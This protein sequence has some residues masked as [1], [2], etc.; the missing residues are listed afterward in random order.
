MICFGEPLKSTHHLVFQEIKGK[1]SFSTINFNQREGIKRKETRIYIGL[2]FKGEVNGFR[3]VVASRSNEVNTSV[4][5]DKL[6][7]VVWYRLGHR[8]MTRVGV[9]NI[10]WIRTLREGGWVCDWHRS[11]IRRKLPR[12]SGM[13]GSRGTSLCDTAHL[14]SLCDGRRA[15]VAL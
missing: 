14:Q 1:L 12:V 7:D 10:F 6:F 8:G 3:Q 5:R 11:Q 2:L 9:S 4:R 13:V 15:H